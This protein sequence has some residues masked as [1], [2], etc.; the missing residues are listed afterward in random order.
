MVMTAHEEKAF[1]KKNL[2]DTPPEPCEFKVND[3]V[4][5][6]NEYGIS[7]PGRKV[8]GFSKKG[9]VRHTDCFV[10]LSGDTPYWF[11]ISPK[12]IKKTN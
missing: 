12:T 9:E 10:H 5:F 4:T 6:T 11:G 3:I 8:I 2:S 1:I 7:F